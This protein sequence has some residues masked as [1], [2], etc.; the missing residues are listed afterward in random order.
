MTTNEDARYIP[1]PIL[2]PDTLR[3]GELVQIEEITGLDTQEIVQALA[4]AEWATSPT[5]LLA[6]LFVNGR[7]DRGE[8]WSLEDAQ[9]VTIEDIASYADRE[10]DVPEPNRVDLEVAQEDV[11]VPWSERVAAAEALD[12]KVVTIGKVEE[13]GH[14]KVPVRATFDPKRAQ[15]E[16]AYTGTHDDHCHRVLEDVVPGLSASIACCLPA[17]HTGNHLGAGWEWDR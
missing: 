9:N 13:V 6:V 10:F 3:L 1:S 17:G 16:Q 5:I 7:R 14:G 12:E 2:D 8:G 4:L 11:Q 15:M